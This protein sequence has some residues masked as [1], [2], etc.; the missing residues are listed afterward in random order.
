M[1]NTGGGEQLDGDRGDVRFADAT[2]L[3]HSVRGQGAAAELFERLAPAL[4]GVGVERARDPEDLA[5]K[6]I[7]PDAT[8]GLDDDIAD[9][10][11]EQ[12]LGLAK[13]GSSCLESAE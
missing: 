5:F 11:K 12:V 8:R 2:E 4:G 1:N 3:F 10:G 6:G 9:F 7:E 13:C